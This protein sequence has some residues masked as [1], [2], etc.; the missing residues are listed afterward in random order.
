MQT[1]PIGYASDMNMYAYAAG[2]PVNVTDPSGMENQ[3]PVTCTGS[4]IASASCAAGGNYYETS[5]DW[6]NGGGDG[7]GA[8][9]YY[10]GT[11]TADPAAVTVYGHRNS[12]S[13]QYNPYV[14]ITG[15]TA[16]NGGGIGGFFSQLFSANG[17]YSMCA[18]FRG[19]S[20]QCGAV[21][22][23]IVAQ[24][25]FAGG[26]M[27]AA[28]VAGVALGGAAAVAG[29]A[30]ATA[31]LGEFTEVGGFRFPGNYYARLWNSGRGAPALMVGE[32]LETA[33]SVLP[34]GM[35]GYY[36][37]YNGFLKLVYNPVTRMVQHIG[38][39]GFP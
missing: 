25:K 20:A 30:S 33:S 19:S 8:A 31:E 36:Q 11:G 13:L 3:W 9:S 22:R 21:N 10:G 35:P 28:P 29:G 14:T 38:F 4:N 32:A 12:F 27:V 6:P 24:S 5:T 17:S 34:D 2:D 1:D 18:S 7:G 16:V 26:A 37:Y 39:E 23:G 15:A